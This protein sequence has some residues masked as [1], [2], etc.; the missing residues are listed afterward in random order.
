MPK[1]SHSRTANASPLHV[2]L[3]ISQLGGGGAERTTI[4]LA[5]GLS[6]RGHRVDLCLFE[7]SVSDGNEI[8]ASV[9]PFFLD[10]GHVRH[11][12]DRLRLARHLRWGLLAF[13]TGKS[14]Q[15]TRALA[16][17]IDKERPDCILPQL[18]AAKVATLLA[19]YFTQAKPIVIPVM[20]NVVMNRS[21]ITR[22]RYSLLFP[23]ADIIVAVSDGVAE[24]LVDR[25]RLPNNRIQRIYNPVVNPEIQLQAQETPSHPWMSG[26]GPPVVLAVGRIEEV[27][28]FP[29][30]VRAFQIVSSHRPARLIV[31]GEGRQ[32]RKIERLVRDMGLQDI[33]AL[34]GW[35]ANPFA[36]MARASVFVLSSRLEG[37]GNV[38]VEALACGCPCVSTDCPSGPA[39][40][41]DQGR[42]GPLVPVGDH[43]ALADAISWTLDNPPHPES[44]RARAEM[45]SFDK[46]IDCYERILTT[47]TNS[48]HSRK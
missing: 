28:D 43:A 24:T 39:E 31:L 30:L 38:L 27:K 40:I 2:A 3:V 36:Y 20:H 9:R 25:L 34:P 7:Q 15:R 14:L 41:L 10:S 1:K 48:P 37:L 33:V 13:L 23:V 44:L 6:A 17:Y 35:I 32:R 21:R 5:R 11:V 8:P 19:R 26:Q 46:A 42:V 22:Y 18:S 4:A 47:A 45:F 12:R 29:T 16:A